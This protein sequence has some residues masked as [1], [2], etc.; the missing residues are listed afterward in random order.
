[1]LSQCRCTSKHKRKVWCE[2][3]L[4]G[5]AGREAPGKALR[6]YTEDSFWS[7]QPSTVPEIQRVRLDSVCLQLKALG[8]GNPLDFDFVDPPPK[9]A[10]VR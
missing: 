8:V 5:L 3:D 1:M 4:V 6:L 9:A 2:S 10:L 7:L